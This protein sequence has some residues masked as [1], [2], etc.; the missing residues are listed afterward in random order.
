[1][2]GIAGVLNR[3]RERRVS[4]GLLLAM[5]AI[6]D[7]R[8]PD[9][10]DAYSVDDRGVGFSHVRLSIVDLDA[11]RARQPFRSSDGRFVSV[12]NGELYDYRRLRADLAARGH[13]FRTKSDSELILQLAERY[14]LEG[15][16]DHL[17]GEFA[18][19]LYDRT[20]DRL[21]LVRDRFGI[22]PLYWTSTGQELVFGSEIKAVLAHPAVARRISSEALLHQLMQTMVPGT[23]AF[24]GVHAVEPGHAV[25]AERRDGTLAVRTYRYWDVDYPPEGEHH[26]G[27]EREC[28]DEL[29]AR[30]VE[31]VRL[32]L[33]ADVPVGCYLSGGVDSCSIM[34][35]AAACQQTPVRAFTIGFDHADYDETEVAREMARAT[36]AIQ[37]V[38]RVR[39][40]E[41]YERFARTI[42]H[43]ER[44]IYNTFC[45]AKLM[46]SEHVRQAGYKV[47]V[48]GEGSDEIFAGY[49]QLRIDHIRHGMATAST[50]ERADLEAW[51][52]DSNALFKGNLLAAEPVRDRALEALIGF[53]PSCLQSWLATAPRA[54]GIMAADRREAIARYEPGAAIAR[55]LR[56]EP[57]EGRCALDK[58]QYVWLKTQF[59]S[60]VLG[61]AGDRVDMAN[62]VEAR[63]AFLDHPLVEFAATLPPSLRLRGRSDK[64]VLRETMQPLLPELLYRRQK[65]AFMAPPAHTGEEASSAMRALAG[66][67][68]GEQAVER[69]AL[70]D[71]G[72]VA[73]VFARHAHPDTPVWEKVQLDALVNHMLSVQLLHSQ[74]VA[75]DVPGRAR[76]RVADLGWS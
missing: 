38:V 16:L 69:A 5:A 61:W 59:E 32:R 57:L 20:L 52:R 19:A 73:D 26:R 66:D 64:H 65:F 35:I 63:P 1:M 43:T 27:S 74:L 8:G 45:I 30:F 6:Q 67:V 23:T 25:I 47:V 18:F 71:A 60:Q 42:W 11:A 53:T 49:P 13:R 4:R 24:E 12:C 55:A 54:R 10:Y 50:A 76:A 31:A 28:I 48:S 41:L 46:L 9:G 15:A 62:A 14:G 3:D 51:L 56:R 39:A 68:L 33:D 22:K 17:R 70:L 29:R 2:C 37:E 44:S 40:S 36:G 75:A 72:A 34:G 21:A 7:H 58:V